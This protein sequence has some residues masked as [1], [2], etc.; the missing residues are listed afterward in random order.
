MAGV[1][2]P[3]DVPPSIDGLAF[4]SRH[5]CAQGGRR[6]ASSNGRDGVPLSESYVR[7]QSHSVLYKGSYVNTLHLKDPRSVQTDCKKINTSGRQKDSLSHCIDHCEGFVTAPVCRPLG[8]CHAFLDPNLSIHILA[9]A[10]TSIMC[11][12]RSFQTSLSWHNPQNRPLFSWWKR[13]MRNQGIFLP[14]FPDPQGNEKTHH[15]VLRALCC[16]ALPFSSE[17]VFTQPS[18]HPSI[19]GGCPSSHGFGHFRLPT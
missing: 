6:C 2:H 3:P 14:E 7:S 18:I 17:K 15:E 16:M 19:H 12:A 4:A 10:F 13:R 1:R 9:M 11:T 5:H 8:I